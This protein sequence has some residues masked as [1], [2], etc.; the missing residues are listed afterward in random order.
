TRTQV[1]TPLQL[2]SP[3]YSHETIKNPVE[4]SWKS[5]ISDSGIPYCQTWKFSDIP[6]S[7]VWCTDVQPTAEVIMFEQPI[8]T[9]SD[10]ISTDRSS[11]STGPATT[12]TSTSTEEAPSPTETSEG[13]SG[14]CFIIGVAMLICSNHSANSAGTY[15]RNAMGVRASARYVLFE[16]PLEQASPL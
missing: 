7:L 16:L 6:A 8:L 11:S 5:Y 2:P 10:T 14:V 12:S 4:M 3:C 9:A 1:T 15:H 13:K